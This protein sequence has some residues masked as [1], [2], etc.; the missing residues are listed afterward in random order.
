MNQQLVS[1]IKEFFEDSLGA[2]MPFD[3][4]QV[5]DYVRSM[6]KN[7]TLK[8]MSDTM[9]ALQQR[10]EIAWAPMGAEHGS[11]LLAAPPPNPQVTAFGAPSASGNDGKKR[12]AFTKKQKR[13]ALEELQTIQNPGPGLM[14]LHEWLTEQV[15]G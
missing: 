7:V 6:L 15:Y 10:G 2:H 9:M 5:Y 1:A 14:R 8:E 12:K 3:M 13:H 11:L 4:G